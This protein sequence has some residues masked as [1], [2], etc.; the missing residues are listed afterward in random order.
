MIIDLTVLTWIHTV[1]SLVALAAG[2]VVIRDLLV[3]RPSAGLT[4]LYLV[5]AVATSATGFLFPFEKF[6]PSHWV[7]VISL[8]VLLLA[9]LG[10]YAFYYAGPWRWIYAI[11][12]VA[13]VYFDMFVAVAQA[14]I[15]IPPLH[16]LAPTQSEPPFALTQLAVLAL[17]VVAAI[18]AAVRFRG[19]NG[20]AVR[21]SGVRTPAGAGASSPQP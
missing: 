11:C 17:F 6:L 4:A 19:T 16:A 1:L 8:V 20:G 2:L 9:I 3:S 12:I 7:G 13:S 15:K 5:T 21:S 10:R 18:A 14:F